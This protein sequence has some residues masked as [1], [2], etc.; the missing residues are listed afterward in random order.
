[1]NSVTSDHVGIFK[2]KRLS[3]LL[4]GL[5]TLGTVAAPAFAAG[6]SKLYVFGDSLVDSG[7]AQIAAP[8]YGLP[9]PA[10]AGFGYVGGRFS[11]GG[12]F[13]DYLS[14]SMFGT[15]AAPFLAGGTN[16]G[17]GGATAR[18]NPILPAIPPGFRQELDFFDSTLQ[19]ISYDSLVLVT[20]GGN[21]VRQSI[22][23]PEPYDFS[24][25]LDGLEAGLRDLVDA[26]AQHI[27]VT[28][29]PDIG[30]LPSTRI[31]GQAEMDVATLRALTLNL[32][33]QAIV[34]EVGAEKG[35]DL[36]YFDLFGLDH[37]LRANPSAFGFSGALDS[38]NSCQS[39]GPAAVIGGCVDYLYFDAIHPTTQVHAV[40]AAAIG[41]QLGPVPEPAT[42]LMMIGGFA[43]AGAAMRRRV[44][45][46]RFEA[47][48]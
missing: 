24:L 37:A 39:G 48:V 17:V 12:N 29:L 46:V 2:M 40:I 36:R 4:A 28:G 13:A 1:M 6:Y 25:A 34:A 31:M 3:F 20:F 43:L 11:N 45:R 27:M 44:S 19:P 41:S 22:G 9:D 16:F 5:C 35:I 32:G 10:P 14:F 8:F 23:S 26:G 18:S 47:A 15:P 7:N 42:W 33:F 21:D 30:L 38:V